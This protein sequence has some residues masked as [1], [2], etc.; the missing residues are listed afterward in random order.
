[1]TQERVEPSRARPE[2]RRVIVIDDDEIMRLSCAEILK[3]AG[4]VVETYSSGQEGI[5]QLQQTRPQLLVVDIKMPELDGFQVM[6][7]VRKIDPEVVIVVITGYA[8]IGTAVDAMKA[9]AYDF[10]PKPFTPDELRLIIN[11]GHERWLL[12]RESRRLRREKEEVERRF[13]T[14]VSHQLKSPLGAVKQY[15]DVLL[16]SQRDQL[17]EKAQ[18]WIGRCQ[19]RVAEMIN[20]IQDWLALAKL[21]RGAICQRDT[22]AD[23]SL[24]VDQVVRDLQHTAEAAGV[25]IAVHSPGPSIVCGDLLALS[26]LVANLVG[27]AIK[28]NRQGGAVTVRT[29]LEASAA[30]LEVED[31]GIGIPDE[32]IPKLFAEFYRVKTQQTQDI[33]GTGLGLAICKKIV[34]ELGG[35]MAVRSKEG[36]GST[37]AARLPRAPARGG[38]P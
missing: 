15:L 24:V 33:P 32:F 38:T 34:A 25:T 14:F 28:Y 29:T 26:M 31:T 18:L 20:L 10:L 6:E 13:V 11:R 5:R 22:S 3:R 2:E 17:P 37:F 16:F 1:V 4:Y 35:S 12:A 21:E 30:L 8:T 19:V 27:N 23:L 9:G 36:E 7:I